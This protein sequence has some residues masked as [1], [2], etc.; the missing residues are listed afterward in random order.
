MTVHQRIGYKRLHI[1]TPYA[2]L[3]LRINFIQHKTG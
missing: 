3:E 2:F 1:Q